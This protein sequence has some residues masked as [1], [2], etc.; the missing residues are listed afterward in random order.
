M[1]AAVRELAE[2]LEQDFMDERMGVASCSILSRQRLIA[3]AVGPLVL[4]A[5]HP[6]M[7]VI[8][9]SASDMSAA[10]L[11]SGATCELIHQCARCAE[12]ARWRPE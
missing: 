8:V 2:A 6:C 11:D 9:N 4:M 7:C 1:S 12:L 10:A 5:D 3:A